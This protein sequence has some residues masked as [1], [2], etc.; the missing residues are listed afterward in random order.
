MCFTFKPTGENAIHEEEIKAMLKRSLEA[1]RAKRSAAMD[2]ETRKLSE[3]GPWLTGRK[4]PDVPMVA[5]SARDSE[6]AL[7]VSFVGGSRERLAEKLHILE[8][9]RGGLKA[10]THLPKRKKFRHIP[11]VWAW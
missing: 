9:C 8:F 1:R 4:L 3:R 10:E 2:R 6:E 7:P 5:L 11:L